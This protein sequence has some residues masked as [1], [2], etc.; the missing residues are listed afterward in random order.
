MGTAGPCTLHPGDALASSDVVWG[1]LEAVGSCATS[2]PAASPLGWTTCI[3]GA[4]LALHRVERWGRRERGKLAWKQVTYA[5]LVV[6]MVVAMETASPNS[7]LHPTPG[8]RLP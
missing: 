1:S 5:R 8:A 6:G 7:I 4:L 3:P 2:I